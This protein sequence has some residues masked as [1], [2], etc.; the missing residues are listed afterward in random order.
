ML[1]YVTTKMIFNIFA[2]VSLPMD[3]WS[4]I[5]IICA[6]SIISAMMITS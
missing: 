4:M 2:V 1:F 3:T 5:D 6:F